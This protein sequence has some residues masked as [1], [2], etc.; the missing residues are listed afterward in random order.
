M[1]APDSFGRTRPINEGS[2]CV[3]ADAGSALVDGI[4]RA[5]YESMEWSGCAGSGWDQL[6]M[7][8]QSS[9]GMTDALRERL[10]KDQPM[11]EEQG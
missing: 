5:M 11:R 1:T 8:S 10:P 3:T 2:P 7:V 9:D 4:A 6:D